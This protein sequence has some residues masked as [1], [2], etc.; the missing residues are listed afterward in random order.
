MLRRGNGLIVSA[1]IGIA[2]VSGWGC[3]VATADPTGS[4]TSSADSA[5]TAASDSTGPNAD[6]TSATSAAP[7]AGPQKPSDTDA[8]PPDNVDDSHDEEVIDEDIGDGEA[9]E[10]AGDDPLES[11]ENASTSAARSRNS[12]RLERKALEAGTRDRVETESTSSEPGAEAEQAAEVEAPA[13]VEAAAEVRISPEVS[14][15]VAAEPAVIEVRP[16]EGRSTPN[17]VAAERPSPVTADIVSTLLAAALRPFSAADNLPGAPSD[18]P[19]EWALLAAARREIGVPVGEKADVQPGATVAEE[20][21]PADWEDQYAGSPSFVHQLVVAGLRIVDVVLKPFGGLLKFTSLRVPLFTDG[22]PPFFLRHGLEVQ[23]TEFDGMPVWTLQPT[24]PTDKYIVALHGGAYVAE[25]SLFHWWTY[26]DMARETGATVVVPLYPLVPEGGTAGVAV[27]KTADFLEQLM[28]Q[29][30]ADDVSVIGDSAGGGLALAAV[31]ELVHRGS[32]VPSRM[33][34]FAPWLDAAVG[35]PLSTRL[36]PGDPLLDVPNLQ[37]A[38]RDWAGGLG[39]TH[40]FVSP[41]HG[42]LEGLPPTAVYSGSL[43]LLTPDTLRLQ[44]LVAEGQHANFAFDLRRDLIHDWGIFAFIPEAGA[45]RPS[46]YQA[47]LGD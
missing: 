3:G 28:A 33:V 22:V 24:N 18:A 26:T 2:V 5:D 27:P 45:V 7:P 39:L 40:R 41:L 25:A 19:V 36:D 12:N 14:E 15:A 20:P 10:S 4:T 6:T 13:A 37:R 46:V 30:G 31:Q 9:T 43:D 23:R 38:G 21:L 42:S 11:D 34:L 1:G 44:R 32:A 35:D 8:D 47:L 17:P 16:Q 29:H